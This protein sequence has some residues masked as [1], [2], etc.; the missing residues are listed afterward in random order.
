[1]HVLLLSYLCSPWIPLA[2]RGR[3]EF[4]AEP[5]D[6]ARHAKEVQHYKANPPTDAFGSVSPQNVRPE[7]G[8]GLAEDGCHKDSDR[9][10]IDG[11]PKV[12]SVVWPRQTFCNTVRCPTICIHSHCSG[13]GVRS[14]S[15]VV[16]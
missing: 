16:L 15:S 4:A 14:T 11:L 6:R 10:D 12:G 7:G 13:V 3:L 5:Q 1:M 2:F 9:I 8:E